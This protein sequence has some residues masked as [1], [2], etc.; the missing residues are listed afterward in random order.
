MLTA[1]AAWADGYAEDQLLLNVGRTW[2]LGPHPE[3]T[4]VWH[5]PGAGMERVDAWDKVFR[6]GDADELEAAFRSVARIVRAGCY[7]EITEPIQGRGGIYYC[8]RFEPLV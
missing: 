5:T 3:Y 6:S 4:T 1:Q 2:R 7:R 8:E